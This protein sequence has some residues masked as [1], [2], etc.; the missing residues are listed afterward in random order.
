MTVQFTLFGGEDPVTCPEP[1]PQP[2]PEPENTPTMTGSPVPPP[3]A[4]HQILGQRLR[5]LGLPPD[6][7]I[8]V[9][10][11]RTVVLRFH[12]ARGLRIHLGYGHA[13]DEVLQAIVRWARPG[14]RRREREALEARFMAFPVHQ[15]VPPVVPAPR[16]VP[17]RPGDRAV[18][19]RLAELHR[20]L[21]HDRFSGAL[22]SI[23]LRL[24]SLMRTRLGE[25]RAER[26]TGRALEIVISRLHLRQHGW[27]AVERTLLHEMVHQWQAETGRALDHG[28][29]FRRKAREVGIVPR[30]RARIEDLASCGSVS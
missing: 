9:H 7:P 2:A 23:P 6:C 25:L 10:A 8:V 18:L 14:L 4:P 26:H 27:E 12:P 16:P 15:H 29:E 5:R 17:S 21:N 28:A 3:A 11:N 20:R 1:A 24:S 30:A 19:D 22:A 13:P